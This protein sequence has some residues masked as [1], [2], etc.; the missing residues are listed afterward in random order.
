M[1]AC[2]PAR[3]TFAAS[4]SQLS[5][6]SVDPLSITVLSS[7]VIAS[8]QFPCSGGRLLRG[9]AFAG[10]QSPT[11]SAPALLALSSKPRTCPST[12]KPHG[13]RTYTTHESNPCRICTSIFIGLKVIQNQHLQRS[14]TTRVCFSFFVAPASCWHPVVLRSAGLQPGIRPLLLRVN[15]VELLR[16]TTVALRLN[17]SRE[18]ASSLSPAPAEPAQRL[19]HAECALAGKGEGSSRKSLPTG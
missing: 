14:S 2:N 10:Q 12:A 11:P 6:A 16:L 18:R 8:L 19:T 4:P 5:R 15:K 9:C 1:L 17:G 7:P 13:I 3:N